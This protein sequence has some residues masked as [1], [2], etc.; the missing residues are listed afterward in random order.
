[1]KRSKC[2]WMLPVLGVFLMLAGLAPA[3]GSA[4]A[5][6]PAAG[7]TVLFGSY[8]QSGGCSGCEP[9]EWT[10]LDEHDG[11]L[12]LISRTGLETGPYNSKKQRATWAE[13]SLRQ[14]LNSDFVSEAFTDAEQCAIAVTTVSTPAGSFISPAT[15]EKINIAASSDT[16]DMV[17]LLSVSQVQAYFPK[18]SRR[19]AP[20]NAYLLDKPES[21]MPYPAEGDPCDFTYGNWWLRDVRKDKGI[22]SGFHVK[23]YGAI[24]SA[25][26]VNLKRYVI[27]PAIW[28]DAAYPFD[29]CD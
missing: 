15:G 28:V 13:S 9:I 5:C 21:G 25:G 26:Q 3:Q 16:Q 6:V 14:W 29:A 22:K 10:V 20:N 7:D 1:M 27:R 19:R 8:V 23:S 4:S 24:A 17:F 18:E 2:Q 11:L 12:L